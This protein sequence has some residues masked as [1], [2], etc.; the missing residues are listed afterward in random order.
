M[1]TLKIKSNGREL[2]LQI[3]DEADDSVVGEIF[4]EH[5]YRIVESIIASASDPILDIGAHA[6]F[7]TLYARTLNPTVRIVAVEPEPGNFELLEK[8]L[9]ENEIVNVDVIKAAL[10]AKTGNRMLKIARD[11][12]N[13]RLSAIGRSD[14]GGESISVYT[15]SLSD[16]LKKCIINKVSLL[17]MDIEGGEFEVFE[18]L[19]PEILSKVDCLILEYH[20]KSGDFRE[21]E[22]LLRE[23]KFAVQVFPSRF[24]KKMGFIFARNKGK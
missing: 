11:S 17:K 10:A 20:Q 15:Y 6:G 7:F 5:E 21:I 22:T 8:H 24:D 1:N 9:E 2:K 16:L 4:R 18:S 3:R 13:H 23:S 14:S 12:H 19:S